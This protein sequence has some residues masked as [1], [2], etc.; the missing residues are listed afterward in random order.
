MIIGSVDLGD[1]VQIRSIRRRE[2]RATIALTLTGTTAD[3]L[4]NQLRQ[5]ALYAGRIA[6]FEM[7][8]EKVYQDLSPG[9]ANQIVISGS[10]Y[11][12]GTALQMSYRPTRT[13]GLLNYWE[14]TYELIS[15]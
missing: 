12:D 2:Q 10:E 1:N 13:P 3:T 11:V 9:S 7:S 14:I 5:Q 15:V 8:G 6:E 4:E